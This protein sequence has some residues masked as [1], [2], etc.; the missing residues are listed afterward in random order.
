MLPVAFVTIS[1]CLSRNRSENASQ[2]PEPTAHTSPPFLTQ[3][4]YF[5]AD[6]RS[7]ED[8]A[9]PALTQKAA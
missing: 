6:V 5:T 7:S 4:S 3:Q 9:S 2:L 8:M 1:L